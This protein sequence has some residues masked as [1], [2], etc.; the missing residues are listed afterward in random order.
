M[1]VL[2]DV[3][4]GGEGRIAAA[5]FSRSNGQHKP[6][7]PSSE[8]VLI[9][10]ASELSGEADQLSHSREQNVIP[11]LAGSPCSAPPGCQGAVQ[12]RHSITSPISHGQLRAAAAAAWEGVRQILQQLDI[13]SEPCDVQAERGAALAA[14]KGSGA[15]VQESGSVRLQ[16]AE[17]WLKE[18]ITWEKISHGHWGKSVWAEHE[19]KEI[20]RKGR[21]KEV[22]TGRTQVV[23][24]VK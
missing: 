13:A 12:G 1:I 21:G 20:C 22:K 17:G 18:V 23:G 24:S 19:S 5:K 2:Q 4:V 9:Q 10:S 7:P 3:Q 8:S 15:V 11:R 14:I 16:K 6:D